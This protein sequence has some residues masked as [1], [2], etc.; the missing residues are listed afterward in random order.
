MRAELGLGLWPS[1]NSSPTEL[2][3]SPSSGFFSTSCK[4]S[5]LYLPPRPALSEARCKARGCPKKPGQGRQHIF[6]DSTHRTER[7]WTDTDLDRDRLQCLGGYV[8]AEQYCYRIPCDRKQSIPNNQGPIC[9]LSLLYYNGISLSLALRN[10]PSGRS[11]Q[12]SF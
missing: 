6:C 4:E 11:C 8:L 2:C 3:P 5:V 12:D 10:W 7:G 1:A 9:Q